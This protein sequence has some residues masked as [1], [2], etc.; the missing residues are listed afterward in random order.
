MQTTESLG[1]LKGLLDGL[2]LDDNKKKQR[3][4]RQ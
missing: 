4:S 1:Y 2:D 3:Y